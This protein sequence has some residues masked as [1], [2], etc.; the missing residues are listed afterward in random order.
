MALLAVFITLGHPDTPPLT[1]TATGRA[2]QLRTARPTRAL[3]TRCCDQST[4]G[5]GAARVQVAGLSTENRAAHVRLLH[6]AAALLAAATHLKQLQNDV[7]QRRWRRSPLLHPRLRLGHGRS[8]VIHEP[9]R[10]DAAST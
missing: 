5:D 2:G 8:G 6:A 10:T 9:A 4:A 1:P 7:P 3:P